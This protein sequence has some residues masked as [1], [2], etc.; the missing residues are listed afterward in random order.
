MYG[1]FVVADGYFGTSSSLDLRNQVQFEVV[2]ED[3]ELV[4]LED[5]LD[6]E[7]EVSISINNLFLSTVLTDSL[8]LQFRIVASGQLVD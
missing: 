1:Y 6:E 5:A 8:P 2:E 3:I 7:K 4:Y